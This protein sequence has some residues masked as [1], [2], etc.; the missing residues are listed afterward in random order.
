MIF[1]AK[2]LA[3]VNPADRSRIFKIGAISNC[4][5]AIGRVKAWKVEFPKLITEIFVKDCPQMTS[6]Y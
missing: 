5:N 4:I 1:G 6:L 3:F 2:A